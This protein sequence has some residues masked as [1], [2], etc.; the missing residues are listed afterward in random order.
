MSQSN[1][2]FI[3]IISGPSGVGK[4]TLIKEALKVT[5]N[6]SVSLSM[7]TRQPRPGETHGKDYLFSSESEFKER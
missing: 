6:L 7:T 1:N 5:P 4:G 3:I 2:G